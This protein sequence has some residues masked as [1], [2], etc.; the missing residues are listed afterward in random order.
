MEY[1]SKGALIQRLNAKT[2]CLELLLGY[3]I[4][5]IT[6]TFHLTT[7]SCYVNNLFYTYAFYRIRC[8]FRYTKSTSYSVK[9]YLRQQ[10]FEDI[11]V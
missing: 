11:S 5:L 3:E 10:I 4:T 1:L 2:R 9:N 6:F 8:R 7:F